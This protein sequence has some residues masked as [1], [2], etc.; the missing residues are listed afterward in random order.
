MKVLGL[1]KLNGTPTKEKFPIN[2][3][4][5]DQK[6]QQKY[7]RKI[8]TTIVDEHNLDNTVANQIISS[9]LN[10]KNKKEQWIVNE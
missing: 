3:S 5:Q 9:S 10:K 7:F 6:A 2:E 8:S 4:K 1:K